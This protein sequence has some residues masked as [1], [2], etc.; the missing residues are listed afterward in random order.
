MLYPE[1]GLMTEDIAGIKE[2]RD[3]VGK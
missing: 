2:R 1:S 3:P